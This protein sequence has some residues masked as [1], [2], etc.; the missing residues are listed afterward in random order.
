MTIAR[1]VGTL[2]VL[3]CSLW[4]TAGSAQAV[5]GEYLV[6]LEPGASEKALAALGGGELLVRELNLFLVKPSARALASGALER[7]RSSRSARY[8]APNHRVALRNTPNDSLFSQQWSLKHPSGKSDIQAEAAWDVATGGADQT[9]TKIVVAVVDGGVEISHPEIAANLWTN[10]A[11]IAGNGIDDDGN[12]YVDDLHGWNAY[13][14]TG[15][16]DGDDHG[17]HVAGIMGARA[18]D[19]GGV[20]GINWNSHIMAVAG[21]SES[22]AQV[23][24]AYGY[25]LAQKK[26]FLSSGGTKGANVVVTNSSFGVDYADCSAAEYQVWNDLYEAMGKVGIL[27]VAA[28]ANLNV[29]VDQVG[30]VPTSCRSEFVIGVTNTTENDTRY[31]RAAFGKTHV[32]LGAPGTNILSTLSQGTGLMTGTS[33]ASPHV[34]GA[35]AL[36][37]A[38]GCQRFSDLYAKSPDKAALLVKKMLL[39]TV[40]PVSDLAAVTVSGGRLNLYKAVQKIYNYGCAVP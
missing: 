18:N 16:L 23:A 28:T 6:R 33:M 26:L 13:N 1:L 21:A 29:D 9:G 20:A 8:V 12:G 37:H 30:D 27:S 15:V 10:P 32:D 40:D 24:K 39:D 22:T 5:P 36:M 4:T 14:D 7:L 2:S 35:V 25:V 38:A 11:E 17:T 34:A 31:P 3:V 19:N